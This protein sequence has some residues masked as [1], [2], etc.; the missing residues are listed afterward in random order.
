[1]FGSDKFFSAAEAKRVTAEAL[2]EVMEESFHETLETTETAIRERAEEGYNDVEIELEDL[3]VLPS[4]QNYL[5]KEG[6][7][8]S[9]VVTPEDDDNYALAVL[10]INW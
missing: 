4:V 10:K 9:A 1:M 7:D 5:S 8:V 3:R 6:Y 2:N